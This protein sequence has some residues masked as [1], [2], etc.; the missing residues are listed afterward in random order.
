MPNVGKLSVQ[1]LADIAKLGMNLKKAE[2]KFTVFGQKVSTNSKLASAG[3]Q[4]VGIA[5]GR[6]VPALAAATTA[7]IG[8]N[9][10]I[11]AFNR[12]EGIEQSMNRSLSILQN[13]DAQMRG[14][15]LETARLIA[16]ET[17]FSTEEAA[18]AYFFLGSA[19]LDAEKQLQALPVVADFAQAGAFDLATATDLLTDAQ[20]ALGLSSKDATRNMQNMTRI[21]D[22]LTRAQSLGNASTQQFS[23]A[24]T[25]KAGPALASVSKS[26]EEG[27]AV[28]AVL[29]DQGKKGAEAGT[30]LSIAL[31]DLQTKAIQNED[32]FRRFGVEVFG[33][34]GDMLHLADVVGSLEG[35][36]AGLSDKA[37]KQRLLELG[38]SDKSIS[39]IQLLLGQSEKIGDNFDELQGV[40][41]ETGRVADANMTSMQ[42]A[43]EKLEAA[44]DKLS[45]AFHAAFDESLADGITAVADALEDIG[46]KLSFA[47]DVVQVGAG[48]IFDSA[49]GS[50]LPGGTLPFKLKD[51][52]DAQ[53]PETT[54]FRMEPERDV[55]TAPTADM[56]ALNDEIESARENFLSSV[57]PAE[58]LRETLQ[59][60]AD[61]PL[62]DTFTMFDRQQAMDDAVDKAT[63]LRDRI[64]DIDDE[65]AKLQGAS[66]ADIEIQR[67]VEQTGLS[68]SAFQGLDDAL[69]K[70]EKLKA[71]AADREELQEFADDL[72]DS[73]MSPFEQVEGQFAQLRKALTEGLIDQDTFDTALD[74]LVTDSFDIPADPMDEARNRIDEIREA[75][76]AG[77][78]N[79]DEAQRALDNI[80]SSA[81]ERAEVQAPAGAAAVTRGS[82]EAIA[83][84][85]RAI[86]GDDKPAKE[87][88][89]LLE[90]ELKIAKDQLMELSKIAS[91]EPVQIN[92]V[93]GF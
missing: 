43:S 33:Q 36:L 68:A 62:S 7:F 28:L 59:Q 89:K 8:W 25:N 88:N 9:K 58:K 46:G 1:V 2:Q 75:F 71:E 47:T 50:L 73:M 65:I 72:N 18:K 52:A 24:L 60:I 45:L 26:V 41:G 64:R 93:T 38:F 6:V 70:L 13:V 81:G 11:E 20:A 4:G 66:D 78:I 27:V 61:T 49:V 84:I 56:D 55:P 48:T 80:D 92:N 19:G 5:A 82:R 44:I 37:K 77:F 15:M 30:L 42:D 53:Q 10:A 3:I 83:S 76:N 14:T 63:G 34:D 69:K 17:V 29:A 57:S 86:R 67:L 31:R 39:A 90:K 23:E 32:A 74:N 85:Q 91:S 16:R 87:T 22:V 21:S 79:A 35:S 40:F 51:I 54:N 12:A